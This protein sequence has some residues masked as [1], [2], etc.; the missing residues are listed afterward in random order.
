MHFRASHDRI[1]VRPINSE[2]RTAGGL[3]IPDTVR[4]KP[5]Q[6]EVVAV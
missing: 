3:T 4:D 2:E 6:G 1:L 5:M